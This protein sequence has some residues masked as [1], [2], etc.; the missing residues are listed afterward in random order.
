MY[1]GECG[2]VFVSLFV[3]ISLSLF[4]YICTYMNKKLCKV[5]VIIMNKW[6]AA[7]KSNTRMLSMIHVTDVAPFK[8]EMNRLPLVQQ[9]T[10]VLN[11]G[12]KFYLYHL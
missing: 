9:E 10:N 6:S 5:V 8:W 7:E 4:I 3:Y 11:F 12:A 2:W 1:E